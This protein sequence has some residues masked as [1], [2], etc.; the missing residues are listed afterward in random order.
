M[1]SLVRGA[2]TAAVIAI[3]VLT[4]QLRA[5]D[6]KPCRKTGEDLLKVPELTRDKT[7]NKLKA[8]LTVSDQERL[9]WFNDQTPIYCGSQH[10]RFFMGKSQTH[11]VQ[12]MQSFFAVL[13][14]FAALREI[15]RTTCNPQTSSFS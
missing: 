3:A 4:P 2:L 8:V 9:I 14:I 15:P 13:C 7:T 10:L 11:K 6:F 5:D 1:R 12:E